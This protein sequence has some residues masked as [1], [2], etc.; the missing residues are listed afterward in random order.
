MAVPARG[1]RAPPSTELPPPVD[2]VPPRV[3]ALGQDLQDPCSDGGG[4]G[5]AHPAIMGLG[6]NVTVTGIGAS[7]AGG[8]TPQKRPQP[9]PGPSEPA[10]P[11]AHCPLNCLLLFRITC[12]GCHR[13]PPF[14]SETVRLLKSGAPT[15]PPQPQ[16]RMPTV[17][18]RERE[19]EQ[20]PLSPDQT[21]PSRERKGTKPIMGE[22]SKSSC[23]PTEQ[24]TRVP[25]LHLSSTSVTTRLQQRPG[26][27]T[28]GQK[29]AGHHPPPGVSQCLPGDITANTLGSL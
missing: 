1:L 6:L 23:K 20:R 14:H 5:G 17:L 8:T 12:P 18:P 4:S 9:P 7:T 19:P 2:P 3:G 28:P 27:R 22:S 29:A 26:V 10:P 25:A 11:P 24:S 21:P 16:A 15:G 13:L